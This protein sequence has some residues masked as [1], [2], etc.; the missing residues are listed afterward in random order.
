MQ[1]STKRRS[2]VV[3]LE[4]AASLIKDGMKLGWGGGSIHDIP[5]AFARELVR[6]G[7]KDLTL[8]PT[9]ASGYQ[10][11]IL[12]GAGCVKTLYTSYVGIDY[13]GAAPNYRRLAESGKLN[14]VEFDEMGLLRGLKAS[15]AGVAF[16]PLPDGFLGTDHVKTNPEFY[17]VI[18]DP[19]TGKKVVVVCPIRPDICVM[20]QD[21]CDPYGNTR[22]AG[23][24]EDLLH[25]ASNQTIITCEEL[26]PLEDTQ[27][28]HRDVTVFGKFVV[29][30]AR[31]PYGAHPGQSSGC[32]EHDQ[33]H[34]K[35]YQKAAKDDAGFKQ[36]LDKYV[37][38]CKNHDEYL[39]KI[40]ISKLLKLRFN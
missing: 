35:E 40:G 37:Y 16:Y 25:Q 19:F 11:D 21:K 28:H 7:V 23:M 20:H 34:L 27:A 36:Y 18:N 31:V 14:I 38:G 32:Y 13:I 6:R 17:K 29:A 15:A 1:T 2:K 5:A 4:E 24:V 10:T 30:V 3:T 12:L 9:N 26:V 8:I 22:E 33:E 39:E